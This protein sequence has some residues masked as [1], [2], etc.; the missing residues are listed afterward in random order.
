M[1]SKF[2]KLL[3]LLSLIIPSPAHPAVSSLQ[4]SESNCEI[5][6]EFG[7][8]LTQGLVILIGVGANGVI[9]PPDADGVGGDDI[10]LLYVPPTDQNP[11]YINPG[12]LGDLC[13]YQYDYNSDFSNVNVGD[14]IYVRVYNNTEIASSTYYGNGPPHVIEAW[15][16]DTYDSTSNGPWATDIINPY[17]TSV[18]LSLFEAI[19]YYGGVLLH[20]ISSFELGNAGFRIFRAENKFGPY[21]EVIPDFIPSKAIEPGGAEYYFYDSGVSPGKI[22]YYIIQDI[23]YK[24]NPSEF[25]P[26]EGYSMSFSPPEIHI[27]EGEGFKEFKFLMRG[28]NLLYTPSGYEIKLEGFDRSEAYGSP[29]LPRK[30]ISLA[31]PPSGNVELV[32][33]GWE[34]IELSGIHLS[35]YMPPV[36]DAAQGEYVYPV[37]SLPREPVSIPEINILRDQ[38]MAHIL[39]SPFIYDEKNGKLTVYTFLQFIL[40]F[41][42][43]AGDHAP[44]AGYERVYA[45]LHNYRESKNMRILRRN[46]PLSPPP[47]AYKFWTDSRKLY[48]IP[49][50]LIGFDY[51]TIKGLNG[52]VSYIEEKNDIIVLGGG[53]DG[54][55]SKASAYMV[56]PEKPLFNLERLSGAP[57]SG[58]TFEEFY[59]RKE[60]S[61]REIYQLTLPGYEPEEKWIWGILQKGFPFSFTFT[62]NGFSSGRAELLL[63][64]INP[65]SDANISLTFNSY[66]VSLTKNI[67]FSGED[68]KI[69]VELP[70]QYINFSLNTLTLSMNSGMRLLV[71]SADIIYRC[72]SDSGS[73]QFP[74]SVTEEGDYSIRFTDPS[75]KYILVKIER[76][77]ISSIIEGGILEGLGNSQYLLKV[78]LSPGNYVFAPYISIPSTE[79][80]PAMSLPFTEGTVDYIVI[81]PDNFYRAVLPLISLRE[82]EG[83]KVQYFTDE[84]IYDNFSNGNTHP[85]AIKNFLKYAFE[86]FKSSFALL[87]GDTSFDCLGVYEKKYGGEEGRCILPTKFINTTYLNTAVPSDAALSSFEGEDFVPDIALGRLPVKDEEELSNIVWKIISYEESEREEPYRRVLFFADRDPAFDSTV[88]WAADML[89]ESFSYSISRASEL[90]VKDFNSSV[91]ESWSGGAVLLH[92]IGHGSITNWGNPVLLSTND[93]DYIH[94]DYPPFFF[95]LTCL[96]A[97]FANAFPS[98]PIGEVALLRGEA[99][100]V[101]ASTGFTTL[102]AQRYLLQS[103]YEAIFEKDIY[104]AGQADIYAK[105]YILRTGD[106]ED[107]QKT[108]VLL[109]DPALRIKVRR[110]PSI[111][112]ENWPP[113]SFDDLSSP[114]GTDLPFLKKS[115]CS[116]QENSSD[117]VLL[118]F[119]FLPYIIFSLRRKIEEKKEKKG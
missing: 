93:F 50:Y 79:P 54:F 114:A 117:F 23:P 33:L 11:N 16:G 102:G 94:T 13:L 14:V 87:L 49:L 103:F 84:Q 66:P 47:F 65:Y 40:N 34:K 60:I 78:H 113:P 22:Y 12:W 107:V 2:L 85:S 30:Q 26:V 63:H 119:V 4:W 3:P 25:G 108:W 69:T 112:R 95:P 86:N 92:Y 17:Y 59:C 75:G 43:G 44:D 56:Y 7:N 101:Y 81:G 98:L 6:N 68:V 67:I 99:I 116:Y 82:R 15:L 52:E 10:L 55:Y 36:S 46:A 1:C 64:L 42:K 80:S 9:D 28:F 90:S 110:L 118:T 62:L 96:N 83:M 8:M 105:T 72:F 106:W 111:H 5:L 24:E 88:N 100:G 76:E 39:L 21:E 31:I 61:E 37:Q 77:N 89:P 45:S 58:K 74:F 48:R 38:R 41:E 104:R 57:L 53:G 35:P 109:G 70:E 20:W 19:S 73:G 97:Y 115:G 29:S 91:I 27:S 51:F 71:K 32:L 18:S